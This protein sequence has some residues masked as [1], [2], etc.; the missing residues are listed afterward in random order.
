MALAVSVVVPARDEAGAI[1]ACL[2]AL[3]RQ[4]LGVG[5]LEVIVVA[6]GTDDTEGAARRAGGGAGFGRFGIVR[7]EDGNK[8]A[9]LQAALRRATAPVV[10][11]LDADT[12]LENDAIA[13]LAR[14]VGDGA[15]RAVHGAPLPRYGSWVSRYW[16]LNRLLVKVLRYDGMLSGECMAMRRD[17]IARLGAETLFPPRPDL[18]ADFHLARVLRRHACATAYVPSARGTT[19]PPWTFRGLTRTMLR[20]RRG[21]LSVASTADAWAQAALSAALVGGAPIALLVAPWSPR[22]VALCLAPLLLYATRLW[23]SVDTLRRRGGGDYRR[24]IPSFLLLDLTGR[25]IKLWAFV[26]RASGRVPRLGFR[27]ERPGEAGV[28]DPRAR[29]I[30]S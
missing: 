16:E 5:A 13:E 29:G 25:A 8:N 2:G 18:K 27:G 7:L 11:L 3:A 1:G 20:S 14:A 9:A 23:W 24:T 10:V 30:P 15:E 4:S 22:L 28:P 19:L 17:T 12:E 26:E 6:A 21:T